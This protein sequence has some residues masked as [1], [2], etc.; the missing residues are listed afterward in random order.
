M[1]DVAVTLVFHLLSVD[2][3][4]VL[5][6]PAKVS[7]N[8]STAPRLSLLLTGDTSMIVCAGVLLAASSLAS[9][10]IAGSLSER[11]LILPET[12]ASCS[13]RNAAM[14]AN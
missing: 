5:T 2:N 3:R 11:S 8:L 4:R 9:A 12:P 6:I 14:I 7:A 1:A 13:Q 10:R